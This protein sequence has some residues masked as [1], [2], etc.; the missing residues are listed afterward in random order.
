MGLRQ[1]KNLKLYFSIKEVARRFGLNAS[2]LRFWEKEF[3]ELAP[4]KLAPRGTRYY[5]EEDIETVRLIH[6]LLK[7]RGMTLA[8]ARR[9][10]KD[11]KET[12]INQMQ[13]IE[14]LK[15]IRAELVALRDAVGRLENNVDE[16]IN[17]NE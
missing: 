4:R 13:I 11:N 9:K 6:D 17:K 10:L 12:T 15:G 3:D 16:R 7:E 8:G 2:T 5:T 1:D 14:K